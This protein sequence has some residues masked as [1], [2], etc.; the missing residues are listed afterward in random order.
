[1]A[2]E[3]F[4]RQKPHV[5]I[6]TIG[7]VDHGKSTFTAAA[8]KALA[9]FG[10]EQRDVDQLDKAPEEK[11]RGITITA[12]HVEMQTA[13]RHYSSV[14][15]PGHMDFV[16]NM[17]TGSDTMDYA[18]LVISITDG[19]MPQT[20]EHLLLVS[21]KGISKIAIFVNKTDAIDD[22]ED[23][24]FTKEVISSDLQELLKR[25]GYS[26]DT[27]I[28]YGSALKAL[29][30]DEKETNNIA[31]FFETI[32]NY[33]PLPPREIDKPFLMP[34]SEVMV[35]S[36]RGTVATGK[37]A[38]GKIKEGEKVAVV[39]FNSNITTTVTSVETFK[40][41]LKV[42][43]AGDN[44]GLLLRGV[45]RNDIRRGHV[46]AALGS[47]TPHSEF[48]A[49]VYILSKEEGGRHTAFASNYRPQ[50]YFR[51]TD[52]TGVVSIPEGVEVVLPGDNVSLKISLISPIAIEEGS[53][54]SIREGGRTVG[55]GIVSKIIK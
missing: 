49:Q 46:L 3:I 44:V 48:E 1:M 52:V 28:V 7:H 26:E 4:E 42:G 41:I 11:S 2:K 14:D 35:I 10:T 50:F 22:E 54:F 5:N 34:V 25:Y 24:E 9:K 32:D 39:G 37:I 8:C 21:K 6:G 31:S 16:K 40:K 33:F 51:T 38:R 53:A 43:E 13:N 36:G 17:I 20:R 12:A 55:E 29:N 45:S 30:G 15:C 18:I 19:V 23:L 47:I 27:P